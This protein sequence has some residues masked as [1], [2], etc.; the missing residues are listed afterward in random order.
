MTEIFERCARAGDE[1][2]VEVPSLRS[3]TRQKDASCNEDFP[4]QSCLP[5]NMVIPISEMPSL[6]LSAHSCP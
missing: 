1:Q 2:S 3:V 6:P 4:A 5:S